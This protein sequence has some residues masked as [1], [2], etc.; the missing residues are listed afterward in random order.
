VPSSDEDS[1]ITAAWSARRREALHVG[2]LRTLLRDELAPIHARLA[3]NEEKLGGLPD[4]LYSA[5][6]QDL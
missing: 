6:A 2:P 4:L 5:T 1:T 3:R